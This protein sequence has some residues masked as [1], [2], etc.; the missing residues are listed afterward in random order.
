MEAVESTTMAGHANEKA[1]DG[2]SR[3]RIK[4][5][6]AVDFKNETTG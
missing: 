1:I 3:R 5:E 6:E 2:L 4:A